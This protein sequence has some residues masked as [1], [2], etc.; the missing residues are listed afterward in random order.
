MRSTSVQGL[1][2]CAQ[3]APHDNCTQLREYGTILYVCFT[4]VYG[5]ENSYNIETVV[6]FSFINDIFS[7]SIRPSENNVYDTFM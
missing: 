2:I 7:V 6:H 4:Y 5:R 3:A 1:N